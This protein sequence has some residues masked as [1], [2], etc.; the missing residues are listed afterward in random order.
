MNNSTDRHK[1]GKLRNQAEEALVHKYLLAR[2]LVDSDPRKL[3]HELHVHQI[4]LE[5]QNNEPRSG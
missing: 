4:E 1:Q 3:L 5:M 2:P